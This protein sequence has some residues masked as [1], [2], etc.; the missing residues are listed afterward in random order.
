LLRPLRQRQQQMPA[1]KAKA[2][3]SLRYLTISY[4]V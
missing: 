1:I 3:N 2:S 4:T